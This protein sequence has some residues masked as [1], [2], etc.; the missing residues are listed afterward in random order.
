M[1]GALRRIPPATTREA[2][3][4]RSGFGS[5]RGLKLV[6]YVAKLL[7]STLRPGAPIKKIENFCR[8]VFERPLPRITLSLIRATCGN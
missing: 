8:P 5:L 3:R 1:E 4:N 2:Q 7:H 6:E